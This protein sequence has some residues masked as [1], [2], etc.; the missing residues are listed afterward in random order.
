[1]VSIQSEYA[2]WPYVI[3]VL[4]FI[5]I[6]LIAVGIPVACLIRGSGCKRFT[7]T[8]LH[9]K[10]TAAAVAFAMVCLFVAVAFAAGFWVVPVGGA[11]AIDAVMWLLISPIVCFL[12]SDSVRFILD[13]TAQAFGA[14]QER[15]AAAHAGRAGELRK[16]E[17]GDDDSDFHLELLPVAKSTSQSPH[18]GLVVE[19]SP[20]ESAHMS[21]QSSPQHSTSPAPGLTPNTSLAPL[22]HQ[23]SAGQLPQSIQQPLLN[24]TER[25]TS[26]LTPQTSLADLQTIVPVLDD[27]AREGAQESKPLKT[28][29]MTVAHDVRQRPVTHGVFFICGCVVA[30]VLIVLLHNSCV[31]NKPMSMTTWASRVSQK[32]L[33]AADGT[34]CFTYVML[35][36]VCSNLTVVSHYVV[37]NGFVPSQVSA[38]VCRR[39]PGTDQCDGAGW[40]SHAGVLRDNDNIVEDRRYI[41][42]VHVS[43]LACGAAYSIQVTFSSPSSTAVALG[44]KICTHTTPQLMAAP[45][46]TAGIPAFS[47]VG[48]GDYVPNDDGVGLLTQAMRVKSNASF[49]FIGGDLGYENNMRTCYRR[50]DKMLIEWMN[51]LQRADDKCLVPIVTAI[52]NHDAGGYRWAGDDAYATQADREAH[53]A[54]YFK[55]YPQSTISVHP[56]DDASDWTRTTNTRILGGVLG[57]TTLDTGHVLGLDA[58][59]VLYARNSLTYIRDTMRLPALVLYHVPTH[60]SIRVASDSGNSLDVKGAFEPIFDD[61]DNA[62]TLVLEN[63]DHAYKRTHRLRA[64][65]VVHTATPQL[66]LAGRGVIYSGDGALGANSGE[67][68]SLPDGVGASTKSTNYVLAGTVL[69][70]GT[71][72]VEAYDTLGTLFDSF[73]A[74]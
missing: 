26:S 48:G 56:T 36:D 43:G 24:E 7:V 59:Q 69:T 38:T 47:F 21:G 52:G 9:L 54:F 41:A 51:A 68:P 57:M 40:I 34:A 35:G 6:A 73:V 1:M 27:D 63:H 28:F 61:F 45:A 70:N 67:D 62:I 65:D 17:G 39:N 50:V 31:C 60:P 55:Y 19:S 18:T 74:E 29:A 3:A 14:A 25:R 37:A 58:A 11:A 66:R 13:P 10:V 20:A 15:A 4:V 2:F 8:S 64:G 5:A 30:A 32:P 46:G 44:K 42:H 23:E 33:C 12:F 72:V 22:Q 49:A 71:I 16:G 53:I